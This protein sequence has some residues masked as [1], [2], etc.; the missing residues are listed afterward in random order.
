VNA[1]GKEELLLDG[2][3]NDVPQDWSPDGKFIVYQ[4]FRS[5]TGT[6]LLLLP[7]QGDHKPIPYLETP[8]NEGDAQFSPDGRWMAYASNESGQAQVYVQAIPAG[9]AKWQISP[10]GGV[11][12]RWRRDGKELFYISTDQKLM[13][14]QVKSGATFEPGAPQP[15]FDI[16]PIYPPIVGGFAYQPTADGQRFLVLS[17]VGGATAP[18][19]NVVLNWQAGLRK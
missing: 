9:G 4:S 12:P 3:I 18:P 8:F 16:D 7:L 11:Q 17:L 13:A 2:G 5:G 19:I 15:L 6:D 14:V 10:A 1:A